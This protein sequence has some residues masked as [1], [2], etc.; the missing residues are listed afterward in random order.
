[1]SENLFAF[2]RSKKKKYHF[3]RTRRSDASF[4]IEG[5]GIISKMAIEEPMQLADDLFTA[6]IYQRCSHK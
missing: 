1:M 4:C 6:I 5:L 2:F 3:A